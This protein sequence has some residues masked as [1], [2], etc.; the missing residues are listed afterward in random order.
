VLADAGYWHT[1]Q[2]ER[3]F[4]EWRLIAASDNLLKDP[5]PQRGK[6]P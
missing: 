3:I 6:H 2:M 1:E 5:G 4:A